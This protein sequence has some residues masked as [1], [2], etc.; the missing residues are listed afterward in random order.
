V[1]G[2]LRLGAGSRALDRV[3]FQA[4]CA[5]SRGGG[6]GGG[7]G[8][9]S[10]TNAP[11]AGTN[12]PGTNKPV[13]VFD[14]DLK[15][16]GKDPFY[17]NSVRR[18]QPVTPTGTGGTEAVRPKAAGSTNLVLTGLTARL[19]SIN[20]VPLAVNEEAQVRVPGGTARIKVKLLQIK[21]NAV[22]VEADGERK[23][24]TFREGN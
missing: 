24:I 19:A 15:S 21:A 9:R 2:W 6:G 11:T 8:T 23:E 1:P 10:S 17:P 20:G 12:A 16:G 18:G 5:P 14:D 4:G 3:R 13:I 22:V 7:G